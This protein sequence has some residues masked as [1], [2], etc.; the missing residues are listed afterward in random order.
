MGDD[1]LSVGGQGESEGGYSV[2]PALF[3]PGGESKVNVA[4]WSSTCVSSPC[5]WKIGQ[6]GFAV[7]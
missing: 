1:L 4:R 3:Q 5:L 6:P 2:R 7:S